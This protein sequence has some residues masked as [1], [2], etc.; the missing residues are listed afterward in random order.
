MS[1]APK[2]RLLRDWVLVKHDDTMEKERKSE[3]GIIVPAG[4]YT[5]ENEIMTT[6]VVIC[7]GPGR[8]VKGKSER[9][10]C[11]VKPGDTVFYNRFLRK[12]KE[13]RQLDERFGGGYVILEEHKD[14]V[15]VDPA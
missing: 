14:I 12:S 8:W 1:E 4:S 13:G 3:G 5:H 10:P 15:A 6:G 7:T 2:I 9:I 11:E